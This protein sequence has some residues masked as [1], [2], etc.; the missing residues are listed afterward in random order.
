M[1]AKFSSEQVFNSHCCF[2]S[3]TLEE[4]ILKYWFQLVK[5]HL[6]TRMQYLTICFL[7]LQKLFNGIG[8]SI[9][10]HTGGWTNFSRG[11]LI[12]KFPGSYKKKKKILGPNNMG[13]FQVVQLQKFPGTLIKKKL[14]FQ[15]LFEFVFRGYG[16]FLNQDNKA[17][18]VRIP[19]MVIKWPFLHKKKIQKLQK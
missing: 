14:I 5:A 7:Y 6:N 10:F 11:V 17:E 12:Q 2:R 18:K 1:Y 3:Q 19:C 9:F 8:Y 15:G 4:S 16:R 13:K